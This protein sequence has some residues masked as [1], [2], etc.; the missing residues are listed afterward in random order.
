VVNW[1]HRIGLIEAANRHI[2]L[3]GVWVSHKGQRGAAA[4]TE[5]A[6]SSSPPQLIRLSRGES[7]PASAE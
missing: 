2:N 7:E 1:R 4:R 5:R 6:H 3:V